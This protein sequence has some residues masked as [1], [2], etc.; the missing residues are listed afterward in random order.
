[1]GKGDNSCAGISRNR[2]LKMK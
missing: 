1:V 2:I